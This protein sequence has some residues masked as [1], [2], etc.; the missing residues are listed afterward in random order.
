[1]RLTDISVR[2]LPVPL[3]G[4]KV[5]Y[6]ETLPNFGCRLSQGGTRTF[7]VRLGTDRQLITIGRYPI[8]SLSDARAEAKRLLAE[9]TLG[10]HR[11]RIMRWDDA[12]KLYLAAC[13]EKNRKRTVDG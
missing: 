12:L 2:N 9:Q 7:I 11:P 4:Q 13:A 5:H 10:K 3:S 6:D 1:M 8:I